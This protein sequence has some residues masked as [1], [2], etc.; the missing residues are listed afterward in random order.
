[1]KLSPHF[2]LDELIQVPESTVPIGIIEA[3]QKLCITLLEP[4]R[5]AMGGPLEITS[6]YRTV[7]HNAAIG[8]AKNSDH[9]FGRAA[10]VQARAQS[11]RSWEERTFDLFNW[12]RIHKVNEI[13]QLI[14]EDHRDS[15][16]K[17]G[18]LW[19]HVSIP[20]EKHPGPGDPAQLLVSFRPKKY[21]KYSD[22]LGGF[23]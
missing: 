14:L 1:M 19:V 23:A 12:L 20:S 3:L 16:D 7:E 10:D 17:P 5:E 11:G 4:A 15:L 18:K 9:C 6:G 13:G 22:S 2:S 8:G 21:E